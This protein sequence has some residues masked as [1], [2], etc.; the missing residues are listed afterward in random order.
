MTLTSRRPCALSATQATS[1][2]VFG[3]E[4]MRLE[5]LRDGEALQAQEIAEAQAE[6]MTAL[7]IEMRREIDQAFDRALGE[8]RR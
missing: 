5:W 3:D 8:T 7:E 2:A 4:T 6:G 1:R